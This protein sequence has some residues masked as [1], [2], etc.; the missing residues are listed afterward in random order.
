MIKFQI[1]LGL[2]LFSLLNSSTDYYDYDDYHRI[3]D[4][5]TLETYYFTATVYYKHSFYFRCDATPDDDMYIEIKTYHDPYYLHYDSDF[6]VDVC[7]WNYKPSYDEVVNG[8]TNCANDIKVKISTGS[9]YAYY[10]YTFNTLN[11]VDYIAFC[12]T[13]QQE[14]YYPLSIYIYSENAMAIWL[15]LIIIFLPCIIVAA[16]VFYILRRFGCIRIGVSSNVIV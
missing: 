8:H 16:V 10:K 11:D 2:C 3:Y 14:T 15:L 12:M 6:K 13:I 5:D 4:V 9:Q 1:I 7:G